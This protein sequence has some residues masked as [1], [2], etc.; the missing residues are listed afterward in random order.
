MITLYW[1]LR[2]ARLRYQWNRGRILRF[3]TRREW[4]F[5]TP[6]GWMHWEG[7]RPRMA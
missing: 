2:R 4:G 7:I 5:I 3:R 1:L 6:T